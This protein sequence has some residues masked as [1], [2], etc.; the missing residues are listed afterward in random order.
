MG[1]NTYGSV[2]LDGVAGCLPICLLIKKIIVVKKCA[3]DLNDPR[4]NA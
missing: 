4:A 2:V 1:V 3:P